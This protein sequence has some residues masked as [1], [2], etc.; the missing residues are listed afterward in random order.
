MADF[1]YD[2]KNLIAMKEAALDAMDY[3]F[4]NAFVLSGNYPPDK[5]TPIPIDDKLL[6]GPG[7]S[8]AKAIVDK[9]LQKYTMAAPPT[10]LKWPVLPP[11]SVQ[12]ADFTDVQNP[13]GKDV[14][15][16]P[17][18]S[19]ESLWEES[20]LFSDI[21]GWLKTSLGDARSR[22]SSSWGGELNR[23]TD[24]RGSTVNSIIALNRGN[25]RGFRVPSE[26]T[27][28]IPNEVRYYASLDAQS[29]SDA[30][31]ITIA[32]QA[33]IFVRQ[34]RRQGVDNEKMLTGFTTAYNLEMVDLDALA[35]EIYKGE[36]EAET[37]KFD[38][39]VKQEM[40]KLAY[41]K[42]QIDVI[43][44]QN[45]ADIAIMQADIEQKQGANLPVEA[46]ISAM[47]NVLGEYNANVSRAELDVFEAETA[48]KLALNKAK[49]HT[50][51]T[52]GGLEAKVSGYASAAKNL[53][54][55]IKAA[56]SGSEVN[57]TSGNL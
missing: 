9:F 38:A 44:S 32:E 5:Y 31:T 1:V 51:A 29:Q 2:P 48:I 50:A 10:H 6:T 43:V 30:Y 49:I 19:R 16:P 28:I 7:F 52:L 47:K 40:A 13:F 26:L 46:N 11:Y 33:D 14:V 4:Q 35:V 20:S 39:V 27:E 56:S 54:A 34:A 53:A 41:R 25:A 37:V 23:A 21:Q 22:L 17:P 18:G 8:D 15:D 3:T 42:E 36:L 57:V 55:N 24:R 12:D 45:A